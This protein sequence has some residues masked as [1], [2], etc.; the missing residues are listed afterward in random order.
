MKK[1]LFFTGCIFMQLYAHAQATP[2]MPVDN[3]NQSGGTLV[4]H[5]PY[6][7]TGPYN[8]PGSVEV[9]NTAQVDFFASQ[10]IHLQPG[11]HAG[12]FSGS[13]YF[14]A[15]IGAA[16][17]FDVVFIEP[18][19][20]YPTV[21][22]FDKLELGLQLPTA[23]EQQ[24]N[25]FVQTGSGINPFDPDQI[26][27]EA[28]FTN[29]YDDFTVYGFYYN[30]F[31]RDPGAMGSFVQANWLEQPTDYHWRVRFAPPSTGGWNCSVSVMLNNSSSPAYQV[32]NI[33]FSCIPS[34]N[35]GW[36]KKGNDDWHLA[37]SGSNTSFF[38][39]GEDIA[40][41]D[42]LDLTSYSCFNGGY[43]PNIPVPVYVGGYLDVLNWISNL[44]NNGGNMVRMA[45][46]PWDY[47][48]EFEQLNNYS[49]RMNFAWELDRVFDACQSNDMKISMEFEF[50]GK[51]NGNSNHYFNWEN[52]PYHNSIAGVD[53][54]E[55]L[56]TNPTAG[57]YINKKLRYFLSRWGYSSSL[58]IFAP[59]GEIDG[60]FADFYYDNSG[61]SL[62]I[63]QTNWISDMMIYAKSLMSYRPLL[64]TTSYVSGVVG[65]KFHRSSLFPLETPFDLDECDITC[66]HSYHAER[67]QN[68]TRFKEI[69]HGSFPNALL[70]TWSDKPAYIQEMGICADNGCGADPNDFEG[71]SDVTYHN[72]LWATAFMGGFGT[73]FPWWQWSN[74]DYREANYPALNTFFSGID[75]QNTNFKEPDFWDDATLASNSQLESYYIRDENDNKVMG[76]VHNATYW[77]GNISQN[78]AD[79]NGQIMSLT[80]TGD[81]AV[82]APQEPTIAHYEIHGLD[83]L[84]NYQYELYFTRGTGGLALTQTYQANIFGTLKPL[85]VSGQADWAYKAY[86]AGNN[87]RIN[88]DITVDTLACNE[89]ST[90]AVGNYPNDTIGSFSYH[91]NFGNGI[92][93]DD[94]ITKVSF[95]PGTYLVTLV[96]SSQ[97]EI[98]DTLQQ[99][100][101]KPSCSNNRIAD[102]INSE[103]GTSWSVFPNPTCSEINLYF[104]NTWADE[105]TVELC[106]VDGKSLYS[107]KESRENPKPIPVSDYPQGLFLLRVSDGE[108]NAIKRIVISH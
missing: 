61:Q 21:G 86:R 12:N 97:G 13:G 95:T 31:I 85:W 32:T 79:R 63:A 26:S 67:S 74:N 52:N 55:D 5:A 107:R 70:E 2:L 78:C 60:G 73:G 10:R 17:D 72:S 98:L 99:Y 40:W 83:N 58:G 30:E 89:D 91:W 84:Q 88:E 56:F 41:A 33:M 77:W 66:M 25:S 53:N 54:P 15:Q 23:I 104:D 47:D 34:S 48:V 3:V 7:L 42:P 103:Q 35:K 75:F 24:V 90:I 69:A 94:R 39:I 9:S 106:S 87:F 44:H 43:I 93:S 27:V 100:I 37:Y 46:M 59:T 29:G 101:I 14:H 81:D 38:A 28:H 16:P 4:I 71:C 49:A 108:K 57:V 50:L 19:Q 96:V 65:S 11:F 18:N 45:M 6:E 22:Q 102:R 92:T 51:D 105:V 62:R 36:L 64:T 76:W 68:I 82:P 8:Q 1:L 80:G 20:Q